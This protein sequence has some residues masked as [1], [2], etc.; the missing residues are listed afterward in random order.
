MKKPPP[1]TY[2]PGEVVYLWP[3]REVQ[4]VLQQGERVTVC[5]PATIKGAYVVV[6]KTVDINKILG[7]AT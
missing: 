7:R 3:R 4:V 2:R 5:W 1:E 6:T